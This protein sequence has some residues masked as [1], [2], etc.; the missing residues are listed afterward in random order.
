MRAV[1]SFSRSLLRSVV[2]CFFVCLLFWFALFHRET[3]GASS[4]RPHLGVAAAADCAGVG[5][6]GGK[7]NSKFSCVF[8]ITS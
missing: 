4:R 2:F 3:R 6:G 8:A 1:F 7:L 5:D